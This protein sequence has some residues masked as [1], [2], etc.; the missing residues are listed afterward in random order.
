MWSALTSNNGRAS[1]PLRAKF[2]LSSGSYVIA[3]LTQT[4][5][6]STKPI[7]M[8]P[9]QHPPSRPPTLHTTYTLPTTDVDMEK[10][11]EEEPPR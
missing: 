4:K 8:P 2:R 10:A 7:P 11:E 1:P 6:H 9:P 3:P 5:P